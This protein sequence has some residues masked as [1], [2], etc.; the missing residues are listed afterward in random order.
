MAHVIAQHRHSGLR[1]VVFD[2][3]VS[4]PRAQKLYERV[5]HCVAGIRKGKTSWTANYSRRERL[6]RSRG[7]RRSS[8]FSL[9][10]LNNFGRKLS[11]L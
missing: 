10:L 11:V 7:F 1:K 2:V 9:K 3:A 4:N 5:R 6:V 8:Y